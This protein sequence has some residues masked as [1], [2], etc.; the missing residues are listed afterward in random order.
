[1]TKFSKFDSRIIEKRKKFFDGELKVE[2]KT[3][4]DHW[5]LFAGQVPIAN[6]IARYEILKQTIHIPGHILE[7]GCFNGAH[8]SFMAKCMRFLAPGDMKLIYGFD[9]FEGLTEFSTSDKHAQNRNGDYKGDQNLLNYFLDFHEIED[10]VILV[11]G[12]IEQTLEI[13]LQQNPHHIYS[14]VYLDTDLYSSTKIVLDKVWERISHGGIMAF[15]EGLS[16]T[17]PG[18]GQA[19]VEFLKS[20]SGQF[21]MRSLPFARQPM[22]YI[23]KN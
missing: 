11:K 19:F 7:F 12:Y 3:I 13:F 21:Q 15:D 6:M 16:D 20:K 18:E 23:I 17:F 5:P 1:M 4:I 2:N 22:F 9:S 8:L 10:T 14:Y